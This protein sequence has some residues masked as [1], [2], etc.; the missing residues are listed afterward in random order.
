M[1]ELNPE[2]YIN[3]EISLIDFNKRVLALAQS[4]TVPLLERIKFVAIVGNNLDEF[5][6][7]RVASYVQ[8][9]NL[10]I[11][12]TRPDG[13]TPSQV[14]TEIRRR[15]IALMTEQRTVMRTLFSELEQQGIFVKSIKQ[16]N[17]H[18]R[19]ALRSYFYEEI[20][21]VL[22]PLAADHAR[23]FPFISNL[24]LNLGVY[25]RRETE[26][27]HPEHYDFVRIKVP[28]GLPRLVD[29]NKLMRRYGN[30]SIHDS[31]ITYLWIDD[32]IADNLDMLFPGMQVI[33]HYPFRVTR[34]ADIDYENENEENQEDV[35]ALIEHSVKER[36][37][38]AVV[39]LSVPEDISPRMLSRL[40]LE[41]E[42]DPERDVYLISGALGSSS[43]FEL[44]AIDRPELKYPAYIP[45]LP[46]VLPQ[47][48]DIFAAIRQNDLLL[49][50]PYDSFTPVEEFFRAAGRDPDVLAI[51]ATLYRVGKNSPIV[52]ALMDARENDKQVAVLVELK[53]RF[54]EENNLEWARAME[55][56]GVHVTYGVEEVAVKTHAKV[57]LVVRKENDGVRRY[58]HLSTGNYNAS[59]ARLYTDL[60]LF[61]SNQ[62]IAED[63]TRLFNRLTGYAPKTVYKRL[64]V[65]P[66][67]LHNALLKLI[68]DEIGAARAGKAARL[69]FKMNQIEEDQIIQKLYEASQAGVQ[70]DLIIRGLCCLRPGVPG[71]SDRIRVRSN[72]GRYLEHARIYYFHNAPQE[73]RVYMG[74]ADL[75]RRNLLN[76]VETVFPL[77]DP[78]LQR[79]ALR[80]LANDLHSNSDAWELGADGQYRRVKLAEGEEVVV[81]Q[82][83]FMRDSFGLD[84][85]L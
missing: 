31:T 42:V 70:V 4:P 60:S 20:Y 1:T 41:L 3:R 79:K 33:E 40:I 6:M 35:S 13:L 34:N 27:D 84:I 37:F 68:D 73:Q 43:L 54:D 15:V 29:M 71:V 11:L 61:T 74:S 19:E 8:K 39:R 32:V 72:V 63:A 80:V 7:V 82:E 5:F 65:A 25:L 76:R 52:Q 18:Q 28:E 67:Y 55:E 2:T 24:S 85:T 10:G 62:E 66:E 21:P 9:F 75:M 16:L 44:M 23:P 53:A 17:L 48:M 38:G 56:K 12:R 50:H 14:L 58:I 49:H 30:G 78:R 64:L 47:G 81:S 83:A 69:V 22:T 51:K 36:D 26:E 77:I 45:R 46:E 59:T 57:A